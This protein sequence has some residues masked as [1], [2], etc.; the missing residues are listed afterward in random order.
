MLTRVHALRKAV[1][2]SSGSGEAEILGSSPTASSCEFCGHRRVAGD[3]QPAAMIFTQSV[4]QRLQV[5]RS[6]GGVGEG[7]AAR[8]KQVTQHDS[9]YYITKKCF[10]TLYLTLSDQ[11]YCFSYT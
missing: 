6:T 2:E 4:L 11:T 9:D 5:K 7:G 8:T 3:Y 10:I 1:A